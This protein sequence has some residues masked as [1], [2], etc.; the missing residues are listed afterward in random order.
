MS[1][2]LCKKLPQTQRLK[3]IPIY[4]L[5]VSLSQ[6]LGHALARA[7]AQGLSGHSQSVW[8]AA[9]SSEAP[10]PPVSSRGCQ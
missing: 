6:E 4:E 3:I 1:F 7:S 8:G 5:P 10:G 2:L 9:E